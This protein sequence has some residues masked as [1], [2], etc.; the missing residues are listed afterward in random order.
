[1]LSRFKLSSNTQKRF[2]SF[3]EKQVIPEP[4]EELLEIYEKRILQEACYIRAEKYDSPE[5]QEELKK[6][7][8]EKNTSKIPRNNQNPNYD[9]LLTLYSQ[10]EEQGNLMDAISKITEID[11]FV[12]SLNV[13]P[14]KKKLELYLLDPLPDP[15]CIEE[16]YNMILSYFLT[17]FVDGQLYQ[18]EVRTWNELTDY[19]LNEESSELLVKH[20]REKSTDAKGYQQT[21]NEDILPQVDNDIVYKLSDQKS[22]PD[23]DECQNLEDFLD[24]I[25]INYSKAK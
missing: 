20:L 23:P 1:M 16:D 17:K 21:I 14:N 5:H 18:K 11:Q 7:L 10:I 12:T 3:I 22:L 13:F 25:Y 24:Y 19:L 15:R 6:V 8:K 9:K 2:Q 4:N